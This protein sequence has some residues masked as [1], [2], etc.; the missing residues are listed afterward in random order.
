M[1]LRALSAATGIDRRYLAR[2]ES[3]HPPETS[4]ERIRVLA[5]FYGVHRDD[6]TQGDPVSTEAPE[7]PPIELDDEL[8]RYTPEQVA[9]AGWLPWTAR[10]IKEL[11][12]ARKIYAHMDGGKITFTREDIRR[13]SAIGAIEPIRTR[14]PRKSAA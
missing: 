14:A 7:A 13:T 9:A 12:Y 11:V 6:L 2:L 1:S 8:R 5:E 10:R 4:G 3:E